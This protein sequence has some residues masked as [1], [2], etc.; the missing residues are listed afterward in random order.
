MA[1]NLKVS[2]FVTVGNERYAPDERGDAWREAIR[3]YEA[4]ANEVIIVSGNL[5]W[6]PDMTEFTKSRIVYMDWPWEWSWEELPKHL[7]LGLSECKGEWAIRCDIDYIFHE[8]DMKSIRAHLAKHWGAPFCSLS[9]RQFVFTDAYYEKGQ[10]PI[11]I[12]RTLTTRGLM[13]GNATNIRTD[14]CYPIWKVSE[15]ER[16]IP[17]GIYNENE[18]ARISAPVYVYD[19]SFKTKEQT[20]EEFHRFARAYYRYFGDYKLGRT[21]EDSWQ[22]FVNGMKEKREKCIHKMEGIDSH[23][24][25]IRERLRKLTP[26]EFAYNGWGII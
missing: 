12:N 23:P 15:N 11:A 7:N 5:N 16:G 6:N 19:Y 10:V 1:D 18:C 17:E 25:F 2:V 4:I 24:K 26:D 9:K 20:R 21:E 13:F 14:L 8:D 22:I 3:S